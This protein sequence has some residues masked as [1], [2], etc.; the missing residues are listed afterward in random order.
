MVNLFIFTYLW[1]L[2]PIAYKNYSKLCKIKCKRQNYVY[3]DY[4][5][6]SMIY[7]NSNMTLLRVRN[8]YII[9]NKVLDKRATE[10]VV[11]SCSVEKVF[12]KIRDPK[13]GTWD[14]EIGFSANFL[15][16]LWSLAFVNEFICFM[17]LCLFCMF[18]ITLSLSMYTFNLSRLLQKLPPGRCYE[19][20][21]FRTRAVKKDLNRWE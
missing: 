5:D 4:N 12:L 3:C 2:W 15:S 10:A 9:Y 14:P 20:F 13:R 19:I 8:H 16:F 6:I 21:K 11:W 17:R 7:I 18:L 1:Q